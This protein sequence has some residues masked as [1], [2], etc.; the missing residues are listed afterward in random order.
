MRPCTAPKWP[1][2]RVITSSNIVAPITYLYTASCHYTL[3]TCAQ[4]HMQAHVS[5]TRAHKHERYKGKHM[6]NERLELDFSPVKNA[7]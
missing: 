1:T 3:N 6:Q 5:S 7:I 2:L 4:K